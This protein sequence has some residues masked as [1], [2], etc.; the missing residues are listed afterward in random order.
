MHARPGEKFPGPSRIRA[1]MVYRFEGL[2]VHNGTLE[3]GFAM[4]E[5]EGNA[6]PSSLLLSVGLS[7]RVKEEEKEE[8]RKLRADPRDAR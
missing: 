4:V 3:N 2:P 6:H 8:E 1:R 7:G 5:G